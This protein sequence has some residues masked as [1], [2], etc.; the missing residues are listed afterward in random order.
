MLS[1]LLVK[2][3]IKDYENTSSER[4]RNSYGFLA[5]LTGTLVNLL[6]F[7]IKL[8]TGTLV[9]S[10]AVTADAFNNLSDAASSLITI[11]GFKLSSRPADKEHPF[12]H[13]RIEYIAGMIVSFMV[14]IVGYQFIKTSFERIVHPS[15]VTFQ[16]IP[17]LLIL[18]SVLLKIWMS[19]FNAFMGRTI[20]SSA[21]KASSY[22]ALW[23]VVT[24]STVALSL[25]IAR[26]TAIPIDGYIGI[27]VALA[28]LMS[29]YNLVKETMSPLLG[30]PPSAEL[31]KGISERVLSYPNISG[32]HDLIIHNYGPGRCMAS[33]HAEIPSDINIMTI[34]EIID[35]AEREISEALNIYLVIHMDPISTNAVEIIEAKEEVEK[36]L[37]KYPLVKS[38]HDFRIIGEKNHKNILFDMVVD[39][40]ALVKSTNEDALRSKIT[41]EIMELHPGYN[42]I[43]TIDHDYMQNLQ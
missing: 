26:F 23:D 5:G 29:G 22:D 4:V 42:C 37:K 35:Q 9:G 2:T 3:F 19:R 6:L 12:G 32:V 43:I 18:V 36:I 13:G 16:L 14:L 24:S 38:M 7:S 8:I 39:Y 17:F 20:N 10:I 31:I 40:G 21:L 41:D 15:A 30:E 34:H 1:K 27:L 11:V 28:I 25:L 33:I